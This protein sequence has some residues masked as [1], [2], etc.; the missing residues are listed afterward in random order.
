MKE[1]TKMKNLSLAQIVITNS[2][3]RKV[4]A[5]KTKLSDAITVTR[6]SRK[7]VPRKS[8]SANFIGPHI[9]CLV[10]RRLTTMKSNASTDTQPPVQML[11]GQAS[12]KI[13]GVS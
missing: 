13:R 5:E 6:N 8:L 1:N 2:D 7:K 9:V 4:S 12:V 3:H 11:K 10:A